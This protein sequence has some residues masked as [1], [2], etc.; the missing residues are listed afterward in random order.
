MSSHVRSL[1]LP[2][3]SLSRSLSLSLSLP[4]EAALSETERERCLFGFTE[5]VRERKCDRVG[6]FNLTLDA[7]HIIEIN[8]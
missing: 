6:E 4:S 8:N 2:L 7:P 1:P 5:R 3:P